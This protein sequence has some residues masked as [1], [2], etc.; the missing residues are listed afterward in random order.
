[1]RGFSS[2]ARWT[3]SH[4][5]P[6]RQGDACQ[7]AQRRW[8]GWSAVEW[9]EPQ[10]NPCISNCPE[11]TRGDAATRSARPPVLPPPPRPPQRR[12]RH[13]VSRAGTPRCACVGTASEG[14]R[15]CRAAIL[16]VAGPASSPDPACFWPP[17]PSSRPF[18]LFH[19]GLRRGR[20]F[21]GSWG[22]DRGRNE[23]TST[24]PASVYPASTAAGAGGPGWAVRRRGRTECAHQ[25]ARG[26]LGNCGGSAQTP[27]RGWSL[28]DVGSGRSGDL[29]PSP[30]AALPLSDCRLPSLGLSRMFSRRFCIQAA[31]KSKLLL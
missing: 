11:R 16:S 6:Q 17:S 10:G 12:C 28:G 21:C 7:K 26:G 19:A 2:P 24:P 14:P 22:V 1:M 30:G 27:T 4:R 3:P 31:C 8:V 20:Q 18:L 9:T 5:V 29:G 23:L 25:G 13:L 15:R